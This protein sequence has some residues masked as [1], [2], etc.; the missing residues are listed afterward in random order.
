MSED[1]CEYENQFPYVDL[2][3]LELER[4]TGQLIPREISARIDG[5]CVG[6]PSDNQLSLVVSEPTE[7]TIYNIIE[8]SSKGE[9]KAVLLK[10]DPG[11]IRL[12]REYIYEVSSVRQHEPWQEWLQSKKFDTDELAVQA[13]GGE[14]ER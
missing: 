8:V 12:A 10:G 7:I 11:L 13:D 1:V 14:G 5:I 2:S 9:Y 4:E 3:K 6:K